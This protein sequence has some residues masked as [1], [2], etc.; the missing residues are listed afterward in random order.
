MRLWNLVNQNYIRE[1]IQ[2][3]TA[4]MFF[5][6]NHNIDIRKALSIIQK[7][8]ECIRCLLKCSTI[9]SVCIFR[10]CVYVFVSSFECTFPV[11]YLCYYVM[12]Y[13]FSCLSQTLKGF[14][15]EYG[16]LVSVCLCVCVS[17][18]WVN[19]DQNIDTDSLCE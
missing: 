14:Q 12:I 15:N 10:F 19:E 8:A 16:V 4:L 11:N 13:S 6:R 7:V 2:P 18:F 9:I 3:L 17:V 5:H 1:Y